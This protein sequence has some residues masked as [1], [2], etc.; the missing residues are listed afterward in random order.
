MSCL[1]SK[2]CVTVSMDN[3]QV[4]D[5]HDIF[6]NRFSASARP[7]NQ[8]G[9]RDRYDYEGNERG[10]TSRTRPAG[11]SGGGRPR[12]RAGSNE[13]TSS[14]RSHRYHN[15][16]NKKRSTEDSRNERH[17]RKENRCDVRD[18]SKRSRHANHKR[19]ERRSYHDDKERKDSQQKI[20]QNERRSH[21]WSSDRARG[22][23][24]DITK[25]SS[26][27][28]DEQDYPSLSSDDQ[29]NNCTPTRLPHKYRRVSESST[30]WA[31]QV[32]EFEEKEARAK[33]DLHQYR[34]RLELWS[35]SGS[36]SSEDQENKISK[37]EPELETDR[38]VLIRRQKQIDF[39][40]NT[41]AYDNY[42]TMVKRRNRMKGKHP[43]TPNKF[44]LTSRRSWDK[45]IKLWRIKL[46]E[47]DPPE[48]MSIKTAK[49]KQA[50]I[51]YD[52][53]SQASSECEVK[54]ESELMNTSMTS[55][56]SD[57]YLASNESSQRCTPTIEIEAMETRASTADGESYQELE[58]DEDNTL[59]GFPDSMSST[60]VKI[61][62]PNATPA[63]PDSYP[64]SPPLNTNDLV[65][66]LQRVVVTQ[67]SYFH[68]NTNP[69]CL[70]S[71]MPNNNTFQVISSNN[72]TH[73]K[74]S[75]SYPP[76][77]PHK[78]NIFDEFNLDEC[79]LKDEDLVL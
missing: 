1:N 11:S 38:D 46:H 12:Y 36:C 7:R 24:K 19:S 4:Q 52:S 67:Q 40:K 32:E 61:P 34:R 59:T 14:G 75:I 31:I 22:W 68:T 15:T 60:M 53:S 62:T 45:Q 48:L 8:L 13:R 72:L 35:G 6:D 17:E 55:S 16:T 73:P 18:D 63:E 57:C 9:V 79:F 21:R 2:E 37:S 43:I 28:V 25:K 10:T 51:Y 49:A 76:K 30:D 41:A 23:N 65:A 64:S 66:A 42:V 27:T 78:P 44:Q 26:F 58:D 50:M 20:D 77:Q 39:G 69:L 70:S 33:R 54:M 71:T 5:R 47:F 29:S 3:V 56:I 74:P